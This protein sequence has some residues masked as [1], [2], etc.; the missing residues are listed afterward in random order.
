[1][2]LLG[3]TKK[4]NPVIKFTTLTEEQILERGWTNEA[5]KEFIDSSYR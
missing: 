3:K 4:P 2:P 5:I 1:M